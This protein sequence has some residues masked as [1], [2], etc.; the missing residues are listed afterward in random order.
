MTVS[1]SLKAFANRI[2][3]RRG[4][5]IIATLCLMVCAYAAAP[6]AFAAGSA[7]AV[8]EG[9]VKI[10][11]MICNVVGII[12][13]LIGVVKV[14]IAHANEDGPAQQK[15]ALMIATGIILI[16]L[17]ATKILGIDFAG[18]LTV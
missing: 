11:S 18:W 8:I 1:N 9:V 16:V 7:S 17:G 5:V 12:F 10:I 13:V 2:T 4:A 3:S 15:A 14:A 6:F